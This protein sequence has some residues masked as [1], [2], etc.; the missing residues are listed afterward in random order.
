MNMDKIPEKYQEDIKNKFTKQ[1]H[2]D[3][4]REVLRKQIEAVLPTLPEREL[5]VLKENGY[6]NY[7]EEEEDP[8]KTLEQASQGGGTGR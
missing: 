3:A 1:E 7:E 5:N 6:I 4:E 2:T 8:D